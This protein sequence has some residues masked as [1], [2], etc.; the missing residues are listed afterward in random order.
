MKL[1]DLIN[2]SDRVTFRAAD[3]QIALFVAIAVGDGAY[4]AT[5]ILENGEAGLK[6]PLFLM[7]GRNAADD[8]CMENWNLPWEQVEATVISD[9]PKELCEALSSFIYGDAGD[10]KLIEELLA[11]LPDEATRE[12]RL[13]EWNDERRSSMNNIAGRA[14]QLAKVVREI[15]EEE[16]KKV[17]QA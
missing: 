8:F 15:I 11:A 12:T 4:G 6:V 2:P 13:A 1:W 3:L 10:R 5:E 7:N 17:A 9:R 16:E 14:N